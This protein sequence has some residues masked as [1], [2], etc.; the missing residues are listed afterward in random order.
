MSGVPVSAAAIQG[1][2]LNLLALV[3]SGACIP[4]SHGTVTMRETV[5]GRLPPTRHCTDSRLKHTSSF[6][7]R[8]ASLLVLELQ[9]QGQMSY[10]ANI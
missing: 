6:S 5:L 10:L 2:P 1:I 7:V 9:S 3:A 4:E 8:E